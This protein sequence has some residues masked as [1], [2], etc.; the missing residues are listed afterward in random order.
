MGWREQP[1]LAGACRDDTQ[2]AARPH[3]PPGLLGPSPTACR[4]PQPP[5]SLPRAPQHR[6][7]PE[8]GTVRNQLHPRAGRG[9]GIL[10]AV[11][12]ATG[13][14]SS[15]AHG[16]RTRAT[17]EAAEGCSPSSRITRSPGC[18]A[19][20]PALCQAEKEGWGWGGGEMLGETCVNSG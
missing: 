16:T 1:W 3:F 9:G 12:M 14:P 17:G 8:G 5:S 19:G 7:P 18:S 20:G 15:P 11:V 6:L 13:L 10:A 2:P 4:Q